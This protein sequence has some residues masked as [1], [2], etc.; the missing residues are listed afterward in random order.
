MDEHATPCIELPGVSQEKGV[1]RRRLGRGLNA[2]LGG[3]VPDSQSTEPDSDQELAIKPTDEIAIE[4]I[5]R[6]PFQPRKEFDK[7]AILELA[8]SLITHGVLQPLLV[9]PQNGRY[10]LI[11]G[12]RR[13]LAAKEA[14]METVP[15]RVLEL[16]DKNVCEV[17]LVENVQ[18]KDLSDLEKAQAFQDYLD[19]FGGTPAD[20]AKQLG[21]NRSTVTNFIRLLGLPAPVKKALSAGRI[22][23][24]HARSLLSLEERDQIELC[25]LIQRA[26]LS[27]RK[28]EDA[29]KKLLGREEPGPDTIPF[30]Q[31]QEGG[32]PSEQPGKSNH[33]VSLE[34]Q[35]RE[36]LGTKVEIRVTGKDTGRITVEFHNNA[37][38]E[39]LVKALRAVAEPQPM[40]EAA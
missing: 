19:R 40:A 37:E 8:E 38:F 34:G 14:G 36:C 7:E 15:C 3:A 4:L 24:G 29:V 5:E 11:A 6:N 33:I 39:R 32:S 26:S 35:L 31:K 27:V 20:L 28:T 10:Q 2:L 13:W 22:S 9:R 18:R 25:K 12:E 17:A 30:E 21:M 23:N 16:E 1:M